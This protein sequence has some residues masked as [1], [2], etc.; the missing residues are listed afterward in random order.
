MCII[1]ESVNN[2]VNKLIYIKSRSVYNNIIC[3]LVRLK[4]QS[5]A[6]LKRY[7]LTRD[8][9]CLTVSAYFIECGR[10]FQS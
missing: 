2:D 1:L 4:D 10:L 8:M 3:K 6:S 9:D 7:F 5:N